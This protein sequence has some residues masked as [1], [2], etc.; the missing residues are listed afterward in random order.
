[1]PFSNNAMNED[2]D[3]GPRPPQ[4]TPLPGMFERTKPEKSPLAS[5]FILP[6]KQVFVHKPE[7]LQD[8]AVTIGAAY[9]LGMPCGV[10]F[11]GAGGFR[12]IPGVFGQDRARGFFRPIKI[13]TP[14]PRKFANFA[15]IF[16]ATKEAIAYG[17]K[18]S[19]QQIDV[20]SAVTAG[21][22]IGA[23]KGAIGSVAVGAACGLVASSLVY[24]HKFVY[25]GVTKI[26]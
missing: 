24:Y 7:F 3:N 8:L 13:A 18:C 20:L 10:L 1:M 21:S 4:Y 16:G 17:T 5:Q 2:D 11:M 14:Y 22:V 23:H 25:D 19:Q 12:S 26:N 6:P 9:I 15:M